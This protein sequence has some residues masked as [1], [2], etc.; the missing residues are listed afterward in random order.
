LGFVAQ[1]CELALIAQRSDA[2]RRTEEELW[3]RHAG[4]TRDR[5]EAH[6]K[7]VCGSYGRVDVTVWCGWDADG[8]VVIAPS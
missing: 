7:S 4:T 2:V 5:G 1:L 3:P 6:R 8:T